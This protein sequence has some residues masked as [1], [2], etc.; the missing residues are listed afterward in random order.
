MSSL[1]MV[2]DGKRYPAN[3]RDTSQFPF[4]KGGYICADGGILKIL[5][6]RAAASLFDNLAARLSASASLGSIM[7]GNRSAAAGVA[8]ADAIAVLRE[9]AFRGRCIIRGL[10]AVGCWKAWIWQRRRLKHV[11]TISRINF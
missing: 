4:M 10:V 8:A 9:M 3:L 2:L 5:F 7:S 1:G 6:L 11:I